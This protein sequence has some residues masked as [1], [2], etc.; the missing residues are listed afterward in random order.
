MTAAILFPQNLSRYSDTLSLPG[1]KVKPV[2]RKRESILIGRAQRGDSQAF[3]ELY[4]AN[5]DKIYRYIYYR[6]DRGSIAEDL[7]ADVFVRAMEGLPAYEDRDVPLLAWL[8]RIAHA[9][10]V[11]YYRHA[12]FSENHEDIQDVNLAVVQDMDGD[13]LQ[14]QR[15][16]AVRRALKHLSA[17]HQQVIVLRFVEGNDLETTAKMLGKSVGAVKSLQFRAVQSLVKSLESLGLSDE[18]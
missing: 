5:V 14:E 13:L 7:T 12:R 2:D 15:A 16:D 18:Q 9:R 10:V 17:D 3:A 11:D 1:N 6:V 8:Y 4:N